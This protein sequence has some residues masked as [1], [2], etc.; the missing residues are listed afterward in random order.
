MKRKQQIKKPIMFHL[1]VW[2]GK[3]GTDSL[4]GYTS[5]DPNVIG[6]QLNA[7]EFLAQSLN[8]PFWGVCCLT[9]GPT[10]D[11]F[12]HAACMEVS[13]QCADRNIPF[14]LC[15]DPWTVKDKATSKILPSPA[16]ENAMIAALLHP[17]TQLIF[18]RRGYLANH[19]VLDFATT[20]NPV[21][22]LAAVPGIQYWQDGTDFSWIKFPDPVASIR[23]DDIKKQN[24]LSALFA[25]FDDG[26]GPD[27]NKQCWDATQPVRIALARAGNLFWD[28]IDA[29]APASGWYHWI[30]N[31]PNEG[32]A[33]AEVVASILYGRIGQ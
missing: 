2:H 20:V 30:W 5:T 25:D 10:Q 24:K 17:D 3:P 7:M 33:Q 14:V 9:Y 12:I 19:P 28:M 15:Y 23:T 31:D 26:T 8:V 6:D 29:A 4:T 32:R 16:K 18:S 13:R 27:R 11:P 21:V 22:V 1:I